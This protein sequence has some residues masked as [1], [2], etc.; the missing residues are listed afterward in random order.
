[1]NRIDP[2]DDY[3][4][5]A[6]LVH[7]DQR[8][9]WRRVERGPKIEPRCF[10]FNSTAKSN[11]TQTNVSDGGTMLGTGS[12]QGTLNLATNAKYQEAGSI[13]SGGATNIGNTTLGSIGAGATVNLGDPSLGDKFTASVKDIVD[14]FSGQTT[15]LL[16]ALTGAQSRSDSVPISPLKHKTLLA[17][18]G[19]VFLALLWLAFRKKKKS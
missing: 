15:T 9:V 14:G 11:T 13:S 5:R 4:L 2:F 1:M 8:G 16:G 12:Q 18:G 10:F 6:G 7:D 17:A 3:R 19:V